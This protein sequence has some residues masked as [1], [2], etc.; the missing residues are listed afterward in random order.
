MVSGK[1]YIM[2][3]CTV[4]HFSLEPCMAYSDPL[5]SPCSH[6]LCR[7]T[8]FFAPIHYACTSF[9]YTAKGITNSPWNWT[10]CF[11]TYLLQV[12]MTTRPSVPKLSRH[13]E[14]VLKYKKRKPPTDQNKIYSW[15][16]VSKEPPL[17]NRYGPHWC[18]D[19]KIRK[20]LN[21]HDM[22]KLFDKGPAMPSNLLD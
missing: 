1:K 15:K 17:T 3:L 13:S 11:L 9:L 10:I 14:L 2:Y 6:S 21:D 12:S 18:W 7:K 22:P 8:V 16:S 4:L 19:K 20:D 5:S